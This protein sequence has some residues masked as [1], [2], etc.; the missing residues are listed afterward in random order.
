MSHSSRTDFIS[1]LLVGAEP[2]SRL[3]IL[4][5][6]REAGW[7][8]HEARDRKGALDC[9]ERQPVQVVVTNAHLPKW[10]WKKALLDLR[11][12]PHPP[13]LVVTSRLADDSMWAEVLNW[14][15]YDVLVEPFDRNEVERVIAS[16]RRHFEPHLARASQARAAVAS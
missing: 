13:Q 7:R 2:Q 1:A 4:E 15:G 6:F 11:R 3:V 16:A 5:T 14:G 9:L 12:M 10:P 8:L